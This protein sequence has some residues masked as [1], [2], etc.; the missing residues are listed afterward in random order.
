MSSADGAAAD[1]TGSP[2]LTRSHFWQWQQSSA[3]LL[4]HP[5]E[6]MQVVGPFAQVAAALLSVPKLVKAS[7]P[8]ASRNHK[9]T[10]APA[11]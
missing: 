7:S 4:K 8:H 11:S 3:C 6:A 10:T 5:R 1:G 9:A 2:K